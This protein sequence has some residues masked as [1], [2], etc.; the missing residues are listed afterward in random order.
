[1]TKKLLAIL[2]ALALVLS[3]AAC[4]S[5]T[6]D[7]TTT[8]E[9]T[10]EEVITEEETE[11]ET[12]APESTEADET[13][14]AVTDENGETVTDEAETEA[15]E[16]KAPE[17]KAEII[18]YYNTA[19]NNVKP[20]AKSITVKSVE[21]KPAGNVEGLPST[22]SKIADSV[23]SGNTGVDEDASNKTYTSAADKKANFPVENETWS[24]KL[25]EADIK[26]ATIKESNGKYTITLVT[27]ADA[28]STNV[29]HGTG[30][31]PKAFNV[32]MPSVINDN[33]PSAVAKMFSVGT[34]ALNY[35]SST[36][37][38]VIDAETGNVESATFDLLWTMNIPLG[39]STVVIPF[40]TISKYTIAW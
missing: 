25:T 23:I 1:M 39:S 13:T 27:V 6:D 28:K 24:S 19:I 30:H 4:G 18:E 36:I 38:A 35:P 21:N 20:S 9:E 16:V 31:A 15:E 7:E 22:L 8:A 34:A 29:V 26:S 3:F 2:M 32:I 11:E 37:T 5:T 14:E 33:V 12:E 10:T 40:E 17:T